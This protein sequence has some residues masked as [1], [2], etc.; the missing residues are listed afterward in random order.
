MTDIH[1]IRK[2]LEAIKNKNGPIEE[3]DNFEIKDSDIHGKGIFATK[4]ISPGEFINVALFKSGDNFYETTKFGDTIN[5][6]NKPNC[7]TR[8]EGKYYRTYATKEI[9]P[10]DEITVDYT[11]N[12]TLEQPEPGWKE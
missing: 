10:G 8:Y 9:N 12:K 5:H 6:Y 1:L 3:I 2:F 4:K 7:R 11:V